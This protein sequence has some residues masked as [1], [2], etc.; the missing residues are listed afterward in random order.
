[1]KT[2][3]EIQTGN[4]NLRVVDMQVAFKLH[5]VISGFH[6]GYRELERILFPP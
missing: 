6:L 1:M 4:V 5:G 3:G 2:K